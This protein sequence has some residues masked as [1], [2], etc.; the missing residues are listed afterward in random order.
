MSCLSCGKFVWLT[1]TEPKPSRSVRT[2]TVTATPS[3][4]QCEEAG[5]WGD[6]A[7]QPREDALRLIYADWLEDH[8]HGERATFLRRSLAREQ[9]L[10]QSAPWQALQAECDELV[11]VHGDVWFGALRQCAYRWELAGGLVDR[12]AVDVEGFV[13]WGERLVRE[14]PTAEWTVQYGN[15]SGLRRFVACEALSQVRRLV[16]EGDFLGEAVQIL[17]T[18]KRVTNLRSLDLAELGLRQTGVR[19]LVLSQYLRELRHLNLSAND[20]TGS[21]VALLAST[22]AFPRLEA[23]SLAENAQVGDAEVRAL[24]Y[25][26]HLTHLNRLCLAG[27][28][29]T[30]ETAEIL[31]GWPRLGE[32]RYLDVSNT[33]FGTRGLYRLRRAAQVSPDLV[34]IHSSL[35]N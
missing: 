27:T 3:E 19:T 32:L 9:A 35:S 1:G 5:L 28:S 2:R 17:S 10:A 16:L 18:C 24:T 13:R 22:R 20:M 33:E 4:A 29:I 6:I 8:G 34:I 31:E 21:S 12:I 26:A 15:W 14:A 30:S 25:S 11:R 23:L 7:A